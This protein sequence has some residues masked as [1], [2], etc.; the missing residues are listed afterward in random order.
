M[1][2]Q[3]FCGSDKNF[4]PGPHVT[5]GPGNPSPPPTEGLPSPL[6]IWSD[7]ETRDKGGGGLRTAVASAL[8][9]VVSVRDFG[10]Y[11]W[12]SLGNELGQQ[13]LGVDGQRQERTNLFPFGRKTTENRCELPRSSEETGLGS[14]FSISEPFPCLLCSGPP[15]SMVNQLPSGKQDADVRSSAKVTSF[16]HDCSGL[17]LPEVCL[18]H[19]N[20]HDTSPSI[21]RPQPT[22]T[23]TQ[24]HPCTTRTQDHQTLQ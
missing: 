4:V 13:T 15:V 6:S 16:A 19:G 3:P 14:Q 22:D 8:L 12:V 20:I 2:G 23:T 17:H 11:I 9:L 10:K 21:T 5:L 7:V 24:H 18:S 1:A